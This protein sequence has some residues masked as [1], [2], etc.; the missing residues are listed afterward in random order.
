MSTAIS[1]LYRRSIIKKAAGKCLPIAESVLPDWLFKSVYKVA[2]SFYRAVVRFGYLRFLV[3][4]ALK[5][6]MARIRRVLKV[7]RIMPYSLV[8]WSGLE[9]TYDAVQAVLIAKIPGALVECGVAR[10]GSAALMGLQTRMASNRKLWL[11]DS[12]EGLPE[13]GERDFQYGVT[14]NHVRP[15]PKGSCLG[16]YTAVE[17]LLFEKLHLSRGQVTMVKGWFQDTL[18]PNAGKIGDIAVLRIDADWYDSVRLCLDTF[19]DQVVSNGFVIIDDYGTCFGAQQAV[20]EFRASRHLTAPMT[21][22]GRGG[23]HFQKPEL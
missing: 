17:E 14:G 18:P 22:D 1:P 19:Y 10:G 9:A 4:A 23:V 20:E 3:Y 12:Y 6:D 5:S 15:L 13:P 11:F 21:P 16:T 7:H 2:F 8:G